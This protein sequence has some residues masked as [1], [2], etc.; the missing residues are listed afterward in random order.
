MEGHVLSGNGTNCGSRDLPLLPPVQ[1]AAL[2]VHESFANRCRPNILGARVPVTTMNLPNDPREK[3]LP[4]DAKGNPVYEQTR[5]DMPLFCCGRN[6][7]RNSRY[8][9]SMVILC[10]IRFVL[11]FTLRVSNRCVSCHIRLIDYYIYLLFSV[12]GSRV[13]LVCVR[14]LNRTKTHSPKSVVVL[15]LAIVGIICSI[16][17]CRSTKYFQF[18]SLRNDTFY[19]KEKFQPEPFEYATKANVGV[20]RYEILEVFYY[21][22]PPKKKSE[23]TEEGFGF[24][25][26]GFESGEGFES[27]GGGRARYLAFESEEALQR[28][29]QGDAAGGTTNVTGAN[30]TAVLANA[31]SANATST[32]A[33]A[34][35]GTA[36]PSAP[37]VL[38]PG[39]DIPLPGDLASP[40]TPS[41]TA[42]P[43]MAPTISNPN[44]KVDVDLNT[45][46]S[47]PKGMKQFDAVFTNA[48][49]GAMWGPI[50][51]GIGT[52]FGLIELCCCIY[53]CS[54]L[55]TALFLYLAFM[56]QSFTLFL[57]LSDDFWYVSGMLLVRL[58]LTVSLSLCLSS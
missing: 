25:G 55:P 5:Q 41:P 26:A 51:A 32:N 36:A 9:R 53:K 8:V 12:S 18:E 16:I 22:W 29:L 39:A 57:F 58:F 10:C 21:P 45:P 19:D 14:I 48:Q 52:V 40:G 20:F 1:G 3:P 17:L 56:F 27:G 50:L 34:T 42:S 11:W 2:H 43:T 6:C 37:E 13:H 30:E 7:G 49:R 38:A 44:D 47:Y 54:W 24:T 15:V 35:N 28:W 23:A 46:K 33:T 31:T 4:E